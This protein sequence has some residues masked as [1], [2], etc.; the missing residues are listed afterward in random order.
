MLEEVGDLPRPAA[1]DQGPGF[2]RSTA[3]RSMGSGSSC[4]R[5]GADPQHPKDLIN[6]Y[7]SKFGG[8]GIV[9]CGLVD[10]LYII[11]FI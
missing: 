7:G 10:I 1:E 8:Q 3:R 9:D 2:P 4:N 6:F 5:L 11:W